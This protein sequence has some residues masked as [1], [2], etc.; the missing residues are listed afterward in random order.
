MPKNVFVFHAPRCKGKP[1][2]SRRSAGVRFGAGELFDEFRQAGEFA[3]Q[4]VGV[5]FSRGPVGPQ[6]HHVGR[7][8]PRRPVG[9]VFPMLE[10]RLLPGEMPLLLRLPRP[11]LKRA[12]VSSR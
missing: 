3:A 10:M 8:I 1:T 2:R 4:V 9:P 12:G 5:A 6:L 11:F 7:L